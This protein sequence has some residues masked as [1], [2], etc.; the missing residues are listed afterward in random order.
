M[1]ERLSDTRLPA[2]I[3]VAGVGGGGCNT[4][5]RM[6]QYHEIPGVAYIGVNT[7]I[8]ALAMMSD[9]L[10]IQIGTHLTHGFGAGGNPSVGEQSARE[11]IFALARTLKDAD[12]VFII[13]GMGG[14][15]GTGAAPIVA[16][17]AKESGAL[18]IA[19]VTIPF[20]FE[21]KRRLDIAL[22][23][24]SK[25]AQRVNNIII[26]PNNQ[27][28]AYGDHDV[29]MQK[30]FAI[31]DEVV[32]E[33][34]LSISQLINVPGEINV[35]LAD[36]KTVM[37]IPGAARMATGW[38]EGRDKAAKAAEQVISNP[39]LN[40]HIKGARGVLFNF[41]GGPDLAIG[42]VNQAA[43]LIA[44]EIDPYARI[45]FGMSL[46][47]DEI[48][49]KVK[50]TLVATGIKSAANGNWFSGI[51]Q[52]FRNAMPRIGLGMSRR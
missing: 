43:N 7:D 39:L 17:V 4:I 1:N 42:E 24:L 46:P 50:L 47:E 45:F 29:P 32:A 6:R 28:L 26:V 33:G 48:E 19:V 2:R 10:P 21:G 38:G 34:I 22:A 13:A 30:A 9:V 41:S 12:L 44:R 3:K 35:D 11:S 15:T 14:G 16:E 18:I 20:S 36:V 51:G 23:G 8:K 40:A 52:S 31:A 49:D 25:L 27:L 5:R 37:S